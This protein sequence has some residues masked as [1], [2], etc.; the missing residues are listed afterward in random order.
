MKNLKDKAEENL[1][2]KAKVDQK[3]AEYTAKLD[4][5]IA[6]IGD[7]AIRSKFI[8]IRD[9]IVNL[10]F[11]ASD[12]AENDGSLPSAMKGWNQAIEAALR[13]IDQEMPP[14]ETKP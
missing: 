8:E 7:E 2:I 9:R 11:D 6:E 3:V 13:V 12:A 5:R 14:T 1:R 10:A 4:G